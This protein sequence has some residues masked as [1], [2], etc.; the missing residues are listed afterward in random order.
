MM[1]FVR[2][3]TIFNPE[4]Q[5]LKIV[6]IGAGSTGSYISL[7]LAKLGFDNIKVIDFDKIEEQNIP[8][9]FYALK[10]V[11]VLK[12]KALKKMINDFTGTQIE[13]ENIKITESYEFDLELNSLIILCV[14]NM[15]ARKL[16]YEKI[17][18]FPIKLIDTRMG[19][20]GY[21]IYTINLENEEEKKEYETRLKAKTTEAPC[22]EKA[23]IYTI[24]SIASECCNIVKKLDKGESYPKALKRELKNYRILS[25]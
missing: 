11:G 25:N 21:Q 15:T 8:N 13:T 17:K 2:Q 10:D 4:E 24:L 7:T 19:G 22:G 23:T 12:T 14:D 6:I 16:V 18:E 1:N 9:Q 20:E 3:K 5:K